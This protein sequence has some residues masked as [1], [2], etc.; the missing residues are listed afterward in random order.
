METTTDREPSQQ[1]LEE[2]QRIIT[3]KHLLEAGVHFGHRTDRWNP[4]MAPYIYGARAGVHIIDLQQTAALFRRAYAFIRSVAADGNPVLFVGTKK[5]AQDVMVSEA[6]RAGH[7]YVA[8]RWLG[9]TLTN[10]K[11]VKQSIDKL[12]GLERMAEDGTFGKL[13]KKE[14]LQMDRLRQKLERNLGGIKDMPKLPGAIFV[15]DPAKEHIAVSEANRL[16]IPVV[17]VADTNAD[18][19]LIT[20]VIPGNDDAIRSI[21]L[22]C[23]KIA[24]ACIEGGRIGKARAVM[25]AHDDEAPE[26]IRVMTGG[27]GPKVEVVSRR[28][29]LPTPEAAASPDVDEDT[30]VPENN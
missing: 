20:H 6:Q 1:A 22:F 17:A 3:I 8:S 13:T 14:V 26:T 18:P 19:N 2:A 4:R 28:G 30:F 16:K 21:K 23:T 27:D 25:S 7:F 15:I 12:R 11:T 24:D 10:W 29:P 9:G 5:Q